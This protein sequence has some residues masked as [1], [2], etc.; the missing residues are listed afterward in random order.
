MEEAEEIAIEF[1]NGIKQETRS[2]AHSFGNI[3][4]WH[5]NKHTTRSSNTYQENEDT[6]MYVVNM[7]ND[8]GFLIVSARKEHE[9]VLAYSEQGNLNPVDSIDNPGM[10][11]FVEVAEKYVTTPRLDPTPLEPHEPYP[12]VYASPILVKTKW[13]QVSP[14]NDDC[15]VI[16]NQHALAGCGPIATAQAM[17]VFKY[18][19]SYDGYTY[20][21]D[22]IAVNNIPTTQIGRAGAAHLVHSIGVLDYASYGLTNTLVYLDYIPN[23]LNAHNYAYTYGNYYYESSKSSIA[24]GRPIIMFGETSSGT[25][26]FW[27]VDGYYELT[28]WQTEYLGDG[29]PIYIPQ[30]SYYVHCNWGWGGDCNGYFSSNVFKTWEMFVPPTVINPSTTNHYYNFSSYLKVYSNIR[31]NS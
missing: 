1:L 25:G 2:D 19:S 29:T 14:F 5:S 9:E 31:P 10:K 28:T 24:M 23:S 4:A 13:N 17:T 27:V 21:W 15:P 26:H 12:H 7:L 8:Q 16:A 22:S 11:M 20:N 30:E 3:Y 18:P 6:L